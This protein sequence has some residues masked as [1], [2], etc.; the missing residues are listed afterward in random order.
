MPNLIANFLDT[1]DILRSIIPR[2][3][4]RI[5]GLAAATRIKSSLIQADGVG[6]RVNGCYDGVK[7]LQVTIIVIKQIG[8]RVIL[9]V[10]KGCVYFSIPSAFIFSS[11]SHW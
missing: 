3:P 9:A 2:D 11:T 7:F 5:V 6:F 1:D 8:H 10:L 4:A